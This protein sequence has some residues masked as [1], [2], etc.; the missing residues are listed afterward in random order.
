MVFARPGPRFAAP[1]Y[2]FATSSRYQFRIVSGVTMQQTLARSFLPSALPFTA[3]RR[4][5]ASVNRTGFPPSYP[6]RMA[7]SSRR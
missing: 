7:F 5:W 4:R 2:F 6:R 1:S 3:R